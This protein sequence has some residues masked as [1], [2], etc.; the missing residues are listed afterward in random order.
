MLG[1]T[2]DY[3]YTIIKLFKKKFYEH[4][5]V[6]FYHYGV[7]PNIIDHIDGKKSNN[8]LENLRNCTPAENVQNRGYSTSISGSRIPGV[9]WCS[10]KQ[11]YKVT[12]VKN[13]KYFHGGF[14]TNLLEAEKKAYE[15]RSAMFPFFVQKNFNFILQEI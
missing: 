1:C 13:N 11:K 9:S 12:V 10:G 4:R 3:G 7:W 6:W 8:K 15:M 2:S 5:I 14:F